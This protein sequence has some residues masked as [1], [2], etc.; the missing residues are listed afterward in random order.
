[1]GANPASLLRSSA[2][3]SQ[4]QSILLRVIFTW[5]IPRFRSEIEPLRLG[6]FATAVPNEAAKAHPEFPSMP[7]FERPPLDTLAPARDRWTPLYLEHGRVEV[8]DASVKWIT[9]D[10]SV[11]RIP[12][13]TVSALIFGPGTC[14]THAAI[15]VCADCNTPLFWMGED[16]MRFYSFG[17]APNHDNS[18]AR[19]HA[20]VWANRK[21]RNRIAR[22]MFRFRFKDAEVNSATVNQLRGMEGKRVK[23]EYARLGIEFGVT[24]KGRNYNTKNWDMSDGIN[25]ALS[26]TN[27]SLYAVTAAVVCSMGFLPQLGFVHEA[28]TLPFVYDVADLYKH[29]TA[30]PAAFEAI[31]IDPHDDGRLARKKLKE[32]IESSRLL[33]RMPNDI[34]VLLASNGEEG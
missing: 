11:I 9:K 31:A 1:M 18:M 33:R 17:I 12:V 21:E 26:A 20:A 25:R 32:R 24:W 10:G 27:A 3:K 4:L 30:W 23:R 15:K 34:K 22:D 8:D 5:Q 29:E 19:K 14:V 7:I 6:Q 2:G 13:A 28:G 16:G